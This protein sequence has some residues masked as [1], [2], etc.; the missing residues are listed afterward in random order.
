MPESDGYLKQ[1]KW[2]DPHRA[3]AFWAWCES[4]NQSIGR[5]KGRRRK[6]VPNQLGWVRPA[7]W[8]DYSET[9]ISHE[10]MVADAQRREE[11]ERL[12]GD[13]REGDQS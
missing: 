13:I 6:K 8:K 2:I 9:S 10:E 1:F 7:G 12:N 4:F 5:I 11:E 3:Q